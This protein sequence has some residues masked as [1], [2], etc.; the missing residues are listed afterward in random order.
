M[1][2]SFRSLPATRMTRAATPRAAGM[3]GS[4]ASPLRIVL[5]LVLAI[6]VPLAAGAQAPRADGPLYRPAT[7]AKDLRSVLFNWTWYMGMLRGLDEHELIV[8]LEY[9][10]KGTLQVDGQPCT[11]TKYRVSN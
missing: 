3:S 8:S 6:G 2:A 11:L 5:G 10:G 7:A 9:Q 4:S 1:A